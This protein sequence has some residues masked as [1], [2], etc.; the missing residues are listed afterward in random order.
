MTEY[1]MKNNLFV[2]VVIITRNRPNYLKECLNRLMKQQYEPYEV[3][4]VDSSNTMETRTIVNKH[5]NIHYVSFCNGKNMAVSRNLG[6]LKA[7]GDV[8]AFIDDDSFVQDNWLSE[9]VKGYYENDVGGVG[10]RVRERNNH[11]FT[12]QSEKVGMITDEGFQ[13]GY[14]D[15][16]K[17]GLLEV[18]WIS[19]CNM[20]FKRDIIK[21]IGGFNHFFRVMNDQEISLRIKRIG[22]KIIFNPLAVI[23]HKKA[24]RDTLDRRDE[25]KKSLISFYFYKRNHFFIWLMHA[26]F[27]KEV[28]KTFL[29]WD[30]VYYF[31]RLSYYCFFEFL[32]NLLAKISAIL[33]YLFYCLYPYRNYLEK[34]KKCIT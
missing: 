22:Y 29:Y 13:Y 19:G 15:Y 28:L 3:I 6:I 31:K 9:I 33:I 32:T 27:K 26:G 20:S 14:F 10:G 11:L 24:K 12:S 30:F 18:E 34:S 17:D 2:S 16:N 25:E 4:V 8:V 5:E 21:K 7:K 1:D 23:Y